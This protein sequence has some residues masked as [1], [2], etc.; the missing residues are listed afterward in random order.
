ME[1]SEEEKIRLHAI[2]EFLQRCTVPILAVFGENRWITGTGTLFEFGAR[3]FLITA[4]HVLEDFDPKTD[5][6][7]YPRLTWEQVGLP[8]NRRAGGERNVWTIPKAV[9]HLPDDNI[10]DVAIVEIDAPGLVENLKKEWH[11]LSAPNVRIVSHGSDRFIVAGYPDKTTVKDGE[12]LVSTF[13]CNLTSRYVGSLDGV[14][15]KTPFDPSVDF[16]LANSDTFVSPAG[17]SGPMPKVQ[18]ISGS[19]VWQILPPDV[20]QGVWTA[21]SQIRVVAVE[22][23]V[24]ENMF[25]RAKLWAV[26]WNIFRQI[27]PEAA[28]AI[29]TALSST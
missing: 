10:Y 1:Q 23:T 28:D 19:S 13:F 2:Y 6:R 17:L 16:L 18:G 27:Y 24:V 11:F 4:K 26:A 8:L 21:E 5:A 15:W 12:S 14:N 29:R 3:H 20:T 9:I 22:T 7:G 25:F